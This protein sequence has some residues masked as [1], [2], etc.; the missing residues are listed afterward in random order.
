MSRLTKHYS[1]AKEGHERIIISWKNIEYSILA[2]DAAQSKPFKPVM[3]VKKILSSMSGSAESGQL[4]A[5]M[6]PTGSISSRIIFQLHFLMSKI[7]LRKDFTTKC[8]CG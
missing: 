1:Q 4:L 5:I 7:R 2:R 6:G 3:K 8:S